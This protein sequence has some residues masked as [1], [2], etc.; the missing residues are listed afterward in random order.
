VLYKDAPEI[1]CSMSIFPSEKMHG[2]IKVV[3]REMIDR[4]YQEE[5][6]EALAMSKRLLEKAGVQ[7]RSEC[8]L[9]RSQ[10]P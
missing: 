1:F 10:E 8:W 7:A 3:S 2:M 6:E 4:H 5:S 9:A